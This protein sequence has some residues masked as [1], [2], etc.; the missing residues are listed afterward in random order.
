MKGILIAA[1]LLMLTGCGPLQPANQNQVAA[2]RPLAPA[3][4]NQAMLNLLQQRT[5]ER[6][7]TRW[8]AEGSKEK[9]KC[10]PKIIYK[11]RDMNCREI[12]NEYWNKCNGDAAKMGLFGLQGGY[13]T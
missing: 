12:E 6:A 1:M 13:D 9:C 10:E 8:E 4:P 2:N 11:K 3:D 5:L 7:L